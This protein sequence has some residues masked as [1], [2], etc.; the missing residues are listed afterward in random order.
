MSAGSARS[1]FG[2]RVRVIA[3][4]L[5]DRPARRRPP[6]DPRR[7]LIAHHLLLGDTLMVSALVA[8]LR[9]NHPQADIAMTVPRA[10][11]PLYVARPWGL[12]VLPWDTRDVPQAL[13]DEAP[14]DLA[15][16]PGDNRHGWLAAAMRARWI[17]A[18]AGDRPVSKNWPIDRL[19]PYPGD[20][21]SWGDM[22]ARL[23]EGHPPPPYAPSQWPAGP[24]T[25]FDLPRHAYAVLHV[26]ASTPLKQWQGERWLEIAARLA[27]RGIEPVW[28][29][30]SAEA[31]L[32]RLADRRA[33]YRSY[34]GAL[35]LAQMRALLDRARLV[36]SP[37]TGVAHLAR[38]AGAP[39]V[40][41]FGPGSA[42]IT[43]PGRFHAA[44][45]WRAVTVDPFPCRNQHVLF[46]R[47]IPWVTR[48]GRTTAECAH[49]RCMDAI[50]VDAVAAAVDDVL[51]RPDPRGAMR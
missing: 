20:P 27:M 25:P 16:V 28:S 30:G 35:D 31:D 36:V 26:G 29:A 14:F 21:G 42:T 37:D 45:P 7:I 19:V 41:L 34:A 51:S 39:S 17:V 12:R 18:F 23:A 3:R 11:A 10:F 43:G 33:R 24:S 22:V 5:R 1:R 32:V 48:C 49:P 15:F 8:K 47:E 6:A 9:A 4:A 13:F 46:R 2:I 44:T 50:D 38:I 40:T